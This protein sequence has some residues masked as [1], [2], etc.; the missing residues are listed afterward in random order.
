MPTLD[1]DFKFRMAEIALCD[2][3]RT[4]LKFQG[5]ETAALERLNHYFFGSRCLTKYKETRNGM[6]GPDYSSK[7]STW[8][9]NGC[10]SVRHVYY[11]TLK[12]EKQVT[13]NASTLH[14]IDELYWRDFFRFYADAHGYKIFMAY[15]VTKKT[16]AVWRR[17]LDIIKRWKEGTTGMP[18]IDALMRELNTTGFMGNRGRQIVASYLALDLQQDWR[19]G[20]YHFEEKLIDHDPQSNYG[21]WNAIAGVGPGR[22]NYFNTTLQSEKFDPDGDFIRKWVPELALVPNNY[23]HDPWNMPKGARKSARLEIGLQDQE[24]KYHAFYP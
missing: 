5:G 17:D 4:A 12:Y 8:L 7:F 3:E 20:A 11:E 9:A 13:K 19:F 10:L 21:G 15:G 23:I 14:F 18:I 24:S 2:D 1:Q 6:I 16:D 22:V